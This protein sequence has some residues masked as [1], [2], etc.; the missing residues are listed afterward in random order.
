M[1]FEEI[2]LL[3]LATANYPGTEEKAHIRKYVFTSALILYEV[4]SY[5]MRRAGLVLQKLYL[6]FFI[7][8]SIC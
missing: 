1:L 4:Q 7:C 8:T 2:W 5:A 6:T 3:I